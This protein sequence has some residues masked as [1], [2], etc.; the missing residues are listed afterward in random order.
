M[1]GVL[2]AGKIDFDSP[3]APLLGASSLASGPTASHRARS[4]LRVPTEDLL[5]SFIHCGLDL[6][7]SPAFRG[8]VNYC[9]L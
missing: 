7:N 1:L 3:E 6:A 5:L 2:A 4:S 9:L 8:G